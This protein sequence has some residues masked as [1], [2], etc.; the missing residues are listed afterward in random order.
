M[1]INSRRGT[2]HSAAS[3]HHHLDRFIQAFLVLTVAVIFIGYFYFLS[4]TVLVLPAGSADDAKNNN[5][6][7]HAMNRS[8]SNDYEHA[9]NNKPKATIGY[10]ITVTSCP[11][12]TSDSGM[13]DGAAVLR[14]SIHRN[15]A[16]S[17]S[18]SSRYDY[19]MYA[20]VHPSAESCARS[21]LQPLGYTVLLRDVPVPLQEIEGEYLRSR[22]E[23]NGCCGEKEFVKL[24]A[25]TL[26][27]HPVVVHL[28]L[29]TL[30]LK[31]L[32]GL[33]D[34]M[35]DGV[36]A[37]AAGE[38]S[39]GQ[40]I[41]VAFNDPIPQQQPIDAF[42]TRDYNMAHSGMKHA[43]VQGGFLVLRPSMEVY[44]EFQEIIRKGDFRQNGGWG[45]KGFGPFYGVSWSCTLPLLL[46]VIIVIPPNAI[47]FNSHT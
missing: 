41:A 45:G 17:T 40:Q 26:M 42:F 5:Y 16:R 33:F 47:Y 10:A 11:Q 3:R 25:Y 19:Q 35:I 18:S 39:G 2:K 20:L 36:S 46:F 4:S 44:K 34:V 43:G 24:Q 31:P 21:Q 14:H 15:S 23:K 8:N 1:N 38:G 12:S 7:D 37:A 28:D 22:V 32:D 29:D 30:V 27:E 9:L 13:L 6:N